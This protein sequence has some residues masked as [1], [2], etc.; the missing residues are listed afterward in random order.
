MR[1][2]RPASAVLAMTAA[3]ATTW[4]WPAASQGDPL[5]ANVVRVGWWSQ[6]PGAQPQG[7]GGF[8]VAEAAQ[9]SQSVAAVE[10]SVGDA[11]SVTTATLKL[12]EGQSVNADNAGLDVCSTFSG[13]KDANPGAWADQPRSDCSGAVHL[14]R[15]AASTSWTGDVSKLVQPGAV[16]DLMIVPVS[17]PVGGVVDPGFQVTIA[18]A[19]LSADGTTSSSS[20][21]AFAAPGSDSSF[22]APPSDSGTSSFSAPADSSPSAAFGPSSS[23]TGFDASVPASPPASAAPALPAPSA[24]ASPS[25]AAPAPALGSGSLAASGVGH[26]ARPWGRLILFVPLAALV[27]LG[28]A[29]AR[30]RFPNLVT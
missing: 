23:G 24:A 16:T 9:Q 21:G 26:H 29:A 22:N 28:A 14:K 30:N 3:V 8:Q 5:T 19:E 10:V 6:Q 25:P 13:W 17:Q 1:L 15:D 20:T 2:R 4:L 18:K 27:G 12:T 7:D 11:Q